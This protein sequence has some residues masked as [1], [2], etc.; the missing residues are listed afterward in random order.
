L[1]L[2]SA[3]AGYGKSTLASRYTASCDCPCAW[4]SLDK[5]DNELRQFLVYLL[6]AVKEAFDN[7][8]LRTETLLEADP[9]PPTDELASYLLNDLHQV[10]EPFI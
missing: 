1:T 10:P 4:V 9:L 6:A 8:H 5:N 2:I 7:I 3:P